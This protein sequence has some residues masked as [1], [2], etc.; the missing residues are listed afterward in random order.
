MARRRKPFDPAAAQRASQD[1]AERKA[2]ITRIR[3]QGGEVKTDR[4]G[5]IISAYRSNVFTV[6]LTR[7][8]ITQ[9]HHDAAYR[10]AN[11]WAAWKRLDGKPD[12][13]G[14][15]IDG[16]CG[17]AELVTDRMISAGRD[18][19]R[20]LSSVE[21]L[22][23]LI[24][25][26]FMVATVEEDRAMQWR[27]VMERLGISTRDRQALEVVHSLEQL[28]VFYEEPKRLSDN[29]ARAA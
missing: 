18:V 5:R 26:A 9:N 2:E 16:G 12:T 17:S 21:P 11:S 28:R 1:L 24:L 8:T 14:A 22:S 3:A 6:L 10:L 19:E 4:A 20:A 27:G 15:V 7:G 13:F 29:R 25:E 23:R